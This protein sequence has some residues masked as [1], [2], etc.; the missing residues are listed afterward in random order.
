MPD[1]R[2]NSSLSTTNMPNGTHRTEHSDFKSSDY[3][4]P[5]T[6]NSINIVTKRYESYI[7]RMYGTLEGFEEA[8][9]KA[10]KT[11]LDTAKKEKE[12]REQFN[13]ELDALAKQYGKKSSQY[14]R[15]EKITNKKLAELEK[16]DAKTL[17]KQTFSFETQS[18]Q[19]KYMNSSFSKGN[20]LKSVS[21]DYYSQLEKLKGVGL[22]TYGADFENN[23]EYKKALMNLNNKYSSDMIDA[24]KKDFKENHKVLGGIADGIKS[25]FDKNKEALQGVLGPLNLII[26]P[27][28]DF[29]GGFGLIFKGLKGGVKWLLGKFSKK[30]PTA[31][32]VLKSGAMGVG[33]LFIGHKLDE[34]MGKEDKEKK[35]ETIK[36]LLGGK[37]KGLFG[38]MKGVGAKI[39][40]LLTNPITWIVSGLIWMAIDAIRGVFKAKEWNTSKVSAGIGGALGGMDSGFKGAFKNMGKWALIGAGI[41]SFFPVVGTLAGGLIGAAIG[42]ILGAIGGKR[43]AKGFDA[44]GRWFRDVFFTSFMEILDDLFNISKFKEIFQGEG[45][46]G[47]K[48]I[49]TILLVQKTLFEL[50]MK[51]MLA[52]PKFMWKL[53]KKSFEGTVVQKTLSNFTSK[54]FDGLGKVWDGAKNLGS[55]AF[56]AV[57]DF[58]SD[59]W[60]KISESE[61]GVFVKNIFSKLG[62]SIDKFFKEN[63][64]GKWMDTWIIQPVKNFFSSIGMWFSYISDA[65]EKDGLLGAISAGTKGM[66]SK[67]KEGKTQ[68]D[69]YKEEKLK[70][71]TSV[72]DAIIRTD[73]SIIK[74][75]PR[76]TLVALKDLPLS[77][78]KVREDT[79]KSMNSLSSG[80]EGT[81]DK[82]LSSIIDLLSKILEKNVQVN[83]PPQTR[84]D[85]DLLMNGGLV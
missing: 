83:L 62:D 67:N 48:I 25:T 72:D 6:L 15:H 22:D 9:E 57:K 21:N 13:K 85:L 31:N 76:D 23:K 46:I 10:T 32:D 60:N 18:K 53:L 30:N 37:L 26:S 55:K 12:T 36:E 49:N 56:N 73:G 20:N 84:S 71:V 42:G 29:F 1:N 11:T 61:L 69:L 80:G 82:N 64:V 7:K 33:A 65:Y 5:K 17:L 14:K 16:E 39:G 40:G 28:K 44:I 8:I 77:I 38:G 3:I 34:L 24:W 63:P 54:I 2:G 74:T 52:G 43:L 79:A 4:D 66:F 35:M 27:L 75:N 47:K 19:L 41:G 51:V 78:N 59:V 70:S 68:Y 45:G 50:P 81:L 58:G